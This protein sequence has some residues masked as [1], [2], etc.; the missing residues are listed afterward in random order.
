[1]SNEVAS[2]VLLVAVGGGVAVHCSRTALRELRA[3]EG[4]RRWGTYRRD[5]DP[6]RFWGVVVG[7][8][9]AALLGLFSFCFGLASAAALAR[10]I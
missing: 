6:L 2:A 3:G 7:T 4:R 5:D 10:I 9:L 1:M 8:A